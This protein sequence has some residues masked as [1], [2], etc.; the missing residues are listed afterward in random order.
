[1]Q[2]PRSKSRVKNRIASVTGNARLA[3]DLCDSI[4]HALDSHFEVGKHVFTGKPLPKGWDESTPEEAGYEAVT[5]RL[6]NMPLRPLS[7]RHI[8]LAIKLYNVYGFGYPLGV[9]SKEMMWPQDLA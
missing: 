4:E 6:Y 7:A 9:D 3:S 8:R 2:M 1:M 5:M